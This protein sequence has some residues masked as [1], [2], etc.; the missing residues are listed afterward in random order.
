MTE[1][2][3]NTVNTAKVVHQENYNFHKIFVVKRHIATMDLGDTWYCGYVSRNRNSHKVKL[4]VAPSTIFE[5]AENEFK[6]FGGVT[7]TGQLDYIL[8]FAG[9]VIGFD[10]QHPNMENLTLKDVISDTKYLCDQLVQFENE[11]KIK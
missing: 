6:C 11:H 10:T 8:N 5:I 4:D 2:E 3:T 1:K 7:F 9:D